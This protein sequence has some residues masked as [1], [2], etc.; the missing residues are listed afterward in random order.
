[1]GLFLNIIGGAILT[2]Y[3][4]KKYFPDDDY[5]PKP[6]WGALAVSVIIILILGLIL[7]YTPG[8]KEQLQAK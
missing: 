3:F 5:Y 8:L 6:I 7:L 2:G 4:F 1:L